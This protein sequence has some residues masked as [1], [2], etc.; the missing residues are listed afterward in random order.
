MTI[1]GASGSLSGQTTV[2]ATVESSEPSSHYN[3]NPGPSL[4]VGRSLIAANAT[5]W[6]QWTCPATSQYFFSTK[7]L[8]TWSAGVPT[9]AAAGAAYPSTIRAYTGSSLAGLSAVTPLLMDS[10]SGDGWGTDNGASIAFLATSGT[11]YYFQIDGRAGATGTFTLRW[12]SWY[13]N[14]LGGCG[15]GG[16]NTD[17]SVQCV[18]A[19]QVTGGSSDAWFPFGTTSYPVMPGNYFVS[20]IDGTPILQ[21]ANAVYPAPQAFPTLSIVDG[22]FSGFTEWNNT[23]AYATGNKVVQL[24]NYADYAC[25]IASSP[26]TVGL[27]PFTGG[28]SCNAPWVCYGGTDTIP[29]N[30]CQWSTPI[31][32]PTAGIIGLMYLA[33]GTGGVSAPY[34]NYM[35]LYFPF[36]IDMLNTAGGFTLSGSGT[37]WSIN[38]SVYNT[39][40]SQSWDQVTVTLLN[41]GGISGASAAI[42][43]V[44]LAASAASNTGA[45]TFT[46]DPTAR[47]VTATIQIARAGIV[48]G[49]LSYP[50]YP[51]LSASFTK[52]S[53][54][55]TNC[56]GTKAWHSRIVVTCLWPPSIPSG[57]GASWTSGCLGCDSFPAQNVLNATLTVSGYNL[58]TTG[59]SL[60]A[61]I[62]QQQ[63]CVAAGTAFTF[64]FLIQAGATSE[65]APVTI[66][67]NYQ[68]SASALLTLP[69][70]TQ[71]ITVPPA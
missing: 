27:A 12:G 24:E 56:S 33:G 47:L 30:F 22:D 5:V 42:T 45:F 60:V 61:S 21:Y 41:T 10:G 29:Q 4:P 17:P 36:T 19:V 69:P 53:D 46:A 13:P 63:C 68:T 26:P 39:S 62:A 2:S 7:A 1:S 67:F 64:D 15:S 37:S 44:T 16:L 57:W 28:G 65:S 59:C 35:L 3:Y 32:H 71:T 70:F 52:I 9:L 6:Y 40:P 31:A 23:A 48:V 51:I 34:P 58:Y 14:R 49:T 20:Y 50:L 11:V 38:L 43:G 18:G 54:T 66:A 25:A 8:V 55:E